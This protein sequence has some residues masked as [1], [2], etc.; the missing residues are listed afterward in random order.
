MASSWCRFYSVNSTF[1]S[2]SGVSFG[3]DKVGV[4]PI[5]NQLSSHKF[6]L[7]LDG[8]YFVSYKSSYYPSMIHSNKDRFSFS[9]S[10]RWYGQFSA[11]SCG[12][13]SFVPSTT[14][15]SF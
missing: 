10:L 7:W 4:H 15:F 8:G 3:Y 11:A 12:R 6:D 5:T 9:L 2:S 1:G 14:H 13:G